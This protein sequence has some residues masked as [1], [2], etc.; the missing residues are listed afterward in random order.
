[1]ADTRDVF[2]VPPQELSQFGGVAEC[3]LQWL[4]YS[5]FLA[6]YSKADPVEA[7]LSGE[8]VLRT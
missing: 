7:A 6:L 5:P 4:R 1:M 3:G 8:K 2:G